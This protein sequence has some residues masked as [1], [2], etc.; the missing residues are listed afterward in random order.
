MENRKMAI[1]AAFDETGLYGIGKRLP[2]AESNGRSLLKSDMQH[3]KTVTSDAPKG[4]QNVLI[5]G[6]NSFESMGSRPLPNRRMVVVSETL[7]LEEAN[8]SLPL[9]ALR[10]EVASSVGDAVQKA[11]QFGNSGDI[12]FIGG[13]SIWE[14]ALCQH[15]CT[16]AYITVVRTEAVGKSVHTGEVYS[17]AE[18]LKSSFYSPLYLRR[19]CTIQDR[20]NDIPVLLEFRTYEQREEK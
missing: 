12:F 2:W 19:T 8:L 7:T 20:W 4:K 15:L 11:M 1:I 13:R 9:D 18:M 14:D 3:F 17:K 16:H 6:R 10:V 5:L